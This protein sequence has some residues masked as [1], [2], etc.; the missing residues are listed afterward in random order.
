[1][2]LWHQWENWREGSRNHYPYVIPKK[3]FRSCSKC[4]KEESRDLPSLEKRLFNYHKEGGDIEVVFRKLMRDYGKM[5]YEYTTRSL[6][7][8]VIEGRR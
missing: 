8:E 1:M 7:K 4:H 3:E 6:V 2:C 5:R